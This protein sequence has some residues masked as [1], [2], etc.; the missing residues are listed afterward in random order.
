MQLC[1]FEPAN[2]AEPVSMLHELKHIQALECVF[3]QLCFFL[4]W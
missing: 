1:I 4:G 2:K 3:S